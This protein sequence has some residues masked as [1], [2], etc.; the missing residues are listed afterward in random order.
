ML[1]DADG[2]LSLLEKGF[3]DI[4]A[5]DP[6]PAVARTLSLYARARLLAGDPDGAAEMSSR[7]QQLLSSAEIEGW[8]GGVMDYQRALASA[9]MDEGDQ[10]L[11]YLQSAIQS[12]W[13]DF[14]AARHEPVLADVIQ[15]PAY[16]SLAKE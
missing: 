14:I 16:E 3:V 15:L 6:R 5:F 9:A 13:N 12:G 11:K 2:A 8:G 10:A 7:A 4:N 1:G